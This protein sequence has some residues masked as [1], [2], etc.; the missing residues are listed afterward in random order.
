VFL[1]AYLISAAWHVRYAHIAMRGLPSWVRSSPCPGRSSIL[2]H[3]A[4][5]YCSWPSRAFG[6][7]IYLAAQGFDGAVLLIP[8]FLLVSWALRWLAVADGDKPDIVAPACW[9]VWC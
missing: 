7:I 4:L 1:F 3:C 8:Q 6:F 5:C 9:A 2:R